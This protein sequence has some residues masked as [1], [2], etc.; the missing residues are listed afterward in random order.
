[1]PCNKVTFLPEQVHARPLTF[2]TG[3]FNVWGGGPNELLTRTHAVLSAYNPGEEGGNALWSIITGER[4]PEGKLT[5][6]WPQSAAH[7]HSTHSPWMTLRQGSGSEQPYSFATQWALFPI[8]H[9]LSFTSFVY[10]NL[11]VAATPSASRSDAVWNDSSFGDSVSYTVS[12]TVTNNGTMAG[13]ETVLFLHSLWVS[14]VVRWQR[15]LS[16]FAKVRLQPGQSAI[17]RATFGSEELAV[18]L[19]LPGAS[20]WWTE[21]GN[22]SIQAC[23][24]VV[25]CRLNATFMVG[26]T[27]GT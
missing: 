18:W 25:D 13:A 27:V 23:S 4:S 2:G 9:G 16:G 10:S 11:V 14:Q 26:N 3:R 1:M 20:R 17:A 8:G 6:S 5:V 7:L 12:V 21:P 15:Q 24:S 19:N 22:Y